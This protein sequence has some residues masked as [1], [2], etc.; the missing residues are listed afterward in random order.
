[1]LLK[2]TENGLEQAAVVFLSLVY[3]IKSVTI[4]GKPAATIRVELCVVRSTSSLTSYGSSKDVTT[5]FEGLLLLRDSSLLKH[6]NSKCVILVVPLPRARLAWKL[7]ISSTHPTPSW[8]NTVIF[9]TLI[10]F[11]H[12]WQLWTPTKSWILS[13]ETAY[14]S[15]ISKSL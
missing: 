11:G 10:F 14:S 12:L 15:H 6:F 1:M 3:V 5:W 9:V 8:R 2:L 13:I 4:H 7:W